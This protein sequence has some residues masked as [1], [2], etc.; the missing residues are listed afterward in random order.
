MVAIACVSKPLGIILEERCTGKGARV[1]RIDP[2]G[3]VVRQRAD[4]LINDVVIMV[5]ER[6]LDEA[7]FDDVNSSVSDVCTSPKLAAS[8][9]WMQLCSQEETTSS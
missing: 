4:V 9:S 7:P 3:N 8:R 5:D 1:A 6:R 2:L